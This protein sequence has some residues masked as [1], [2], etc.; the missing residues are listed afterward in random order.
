MVDDDAVNIIIIIVVVVAVRVTR[1]SVTSAASSYT[2]THI[3]ITTT[4]IYRIVRLSVTHVLC[5]RLL[6]R[7]PRSS[8]YNTYVDNGQ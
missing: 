8:S 3:T 6:L 7:P 2:R 5:V 4:I 1:K